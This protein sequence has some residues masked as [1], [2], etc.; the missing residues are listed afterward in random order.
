M[1][2]GDFVGPGSPT[3]SLASNG[4]S[5]LKSA[6]LD[7]TGLVSGW[8][9]RLKPLLFATVFEVW[10]VGV[11]FPTAGHDRRTEIVILAQAV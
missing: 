4:Y 7:V 8:L 6:A 10:V 11:E 5:T 1:R 9:S 2:R 3:N